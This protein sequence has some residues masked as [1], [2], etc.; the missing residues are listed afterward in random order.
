MYLYIIFLIII[1][2]SLL[3]N[4]IIS[5]YI[6]FY[7]SLRTA[8]ALFDGLKRSISLVIVSAV[9]EGLERDLKTLGEE[10]RRCIASEVKI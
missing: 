1:L 3:A 6:V 5:L 9:E 2:R 4:N 10:G 8:S 7:F